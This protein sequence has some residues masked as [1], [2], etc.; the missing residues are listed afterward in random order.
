MKQSQ[1]KKQVGIQIKNR[2]K[3]L[4]LTQEEFGF[5]ID[6][7]RASIINIEAGRCSTTLEGLL[8]ICTVLKCTPNDILPLDYI[9]VSPTGNDF[10]AVKLN[11]KSKKLQAQ[12][13]DVKRQ[14]EEIK[15][16][17]KLIQL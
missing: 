15:K 5:M 16:Q 7:T 8:N 2:R 14:Q 4:N 10:K 13:A 11:A 9:F 1:F 17:S 6:L 12:L 3:A